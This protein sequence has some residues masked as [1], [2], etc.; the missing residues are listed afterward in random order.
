MLRYY[1][2]RFNT[3]EINNTFYKMPNAKTLESWCEQTPAEFRFSIKAS[4]RI[5][6]QNRLK[7]TD[8]SVQYLFTQV[9]TLGDRI[10]PVLFQLPPFLKKDTQRLAAF[11]AVLPTDIMCALEFRSTDW[12]CEEVYDLLRAKDVSLGFA[13]GEVEGDPFVSTASRGYVR[14]RHEDY[15][16]QSLQ[17]W[18]KRIRDQKWREAYVY[19]KHED[20]GSGPKI[21]TRFR[22]E[23]GEP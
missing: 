23:F 22:E 13:D 8:D 9:R 7:E 20:E 17:K 4:R 3:V 19:F 14:L 12:F 10:G 15:D 21:A 6:H 5:T 11:L 18:V 2:E 1:G 16:K